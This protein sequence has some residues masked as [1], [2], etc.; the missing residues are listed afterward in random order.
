[1]ILIKSRFDYKGKQ[2]KKAEPVNRVT[3][4]AKM[5]KELPAYKTTTLYNYQII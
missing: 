4:R 2:N 5:A 3:E 1:M